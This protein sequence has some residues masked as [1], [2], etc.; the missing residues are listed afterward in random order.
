M[1]CKWDRRPIETEDLDKKAL[2]CSCFYTSEK[3]PFTSAIGIPTF[4]YR[5]NKMSDSEYYLYHRTDIIRSFRKVR[6]WL[7]CKR[8]IK[9]IFK[10]T[11]NSPKSAL[12]HCS[13]EPDEMKNR[14]MCSDRIKY[15]RYASK[16]L[17]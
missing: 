2:S 8:N 15:D 7:V 14:P 16:K 3:G 17:L 6:P 13:A 12:F 11:E 5:L 4:P 1:F 10:S 9:G